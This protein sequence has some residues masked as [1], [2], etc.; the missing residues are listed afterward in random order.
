[1]P[2]PFRSKSGSRQSPSLPRFGFVSL[3]GHNRRAGR[4]TPRGAFKKR[5]TTPCK[6]KS[7]IACCGFYGRM[8]GCNW[9]FCIAM[10]C[11]RSFAKS[12]SRTNLGAS[13]L[14]ERTAAEMRAR[15]RIPPRVTVSKRGCGS[16][17]LRAS[18]YALLG[19]RKRPTPIQVRSITRPVRLPPRISC[20]DNCD[21]WSASSPSAKRQTPSTFATE[22]GMSAKWPITD[23]GPTLKGP[24]GFLEYSVNKPLVRNRRL[25]HRIQTRIRQYRVNA[26]YCELDVRYFGG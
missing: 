26:F 20:R 4:G 10:T 23:L 8:V 5:K 9:I 2:P 24:Y 16:S 18:P 25:G 11:V 3:S 14:D 15:S 6:A 17:V 1:L 21:P 13:R 7:R 12:R 22:F 19:L